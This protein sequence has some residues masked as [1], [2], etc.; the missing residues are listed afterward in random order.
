MMLFVIVIH[1]KFIKYCIEHK[2][3]DDYTNEEQ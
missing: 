3:Y 2:R 1:T